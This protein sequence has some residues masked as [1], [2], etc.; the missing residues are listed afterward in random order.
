MKWIALLLLLQCFIYKEVHSPLAW[1]LGITITADRL[2][3]VIILIVAISKLLSGG[4]QF[5]GLGK[6]AA[7]MLLFALT[8]TASSIVSGNA[9]ERGV[10]GYDRF[11]RLFDFIYVPFL[12]FLIAKSVPHNQRKLEF[13]SFAFLLLGAYLAINGAFEHLGLH[14]LVWPK[15]ILDR[16]VGIQF[17]RTRGPFA[18][19][20]ALGGALLV[21]FL[22][23]MRSTTHAK[24][25]KLCWAYVMTF[26]TAAVIYTT[27]QRSTWL[28]FA[29]CVTLL[30]IVKSRM[31]RVAWLMAL[32]IFLGFFAGV[33]SKFSFTGATLFSKRQETVDYRWVN[34]RADLEMIKANPIFGIGWSNFK[35]E[36]RK[37]VRPIAEVDFKELTDGNH[38]TFL[39]LLAEVG[40]VGTLPYLLILYNMFRVGLRVFRRGGGFEREFALILLLVVCSYLIEANFSDYRTTQFF[41]TVLFLLFGTVAGIDAQMAFPSSRPRGSVMTN[42]S[43]ASLCSG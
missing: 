16:N 6:V 18:S 21:T 7:Y 25:G 29:L 36:W 39:G 8:C 26:L 14:A 19:S 38:N 3:F 11:T 43:T 30:V 37:Y 5:T 12:V 23:Y 24:G 28:C 10:A 1:E 4:L 13:L 15:Y 42:R 35:A 32:L 27:N 22:F 9:L 40:L 41:N 31:R 33:A 20:V 2:V 17:E 34:Y